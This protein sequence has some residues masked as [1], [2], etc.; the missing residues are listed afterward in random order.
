MIRG[1]SHITLSVRDLEES[2]LFYKDTLGFKPL[3]RRVKS[4]YFLAGDLWF[5]I[6]E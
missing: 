1:L 2:F 3:L 5:C 4:V 6:E